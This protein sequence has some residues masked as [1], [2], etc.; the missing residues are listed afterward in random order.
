MTQSIEFI[1]ISKRSAVENSG[2]VELVS[3]QLVRGL[4]QFGHSE[5]LLLEAG[6][7]GTQSNRNVRH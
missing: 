4:L 1:L 7:S 5:L 6:S 2:T 3:S